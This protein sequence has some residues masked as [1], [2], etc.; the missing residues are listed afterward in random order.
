MM[1]KVLCVLLALLMVFSCVACGSGSGKDVSITF[2]STPILKEAEMQTFIDDFEKEHP[3]IHVELEYQTWEGIAEKLQIALSTGDTPDVYLDGAART[4]TLPA[5]GVLAPVDDVVGA[6]D[7]WQP[8]VKSFGVMDGTHYLV[9]ASQIGASFLTVNV[10]LAK[11]LGVYDMLPED[12]ISWTLQD[13]YEFVKACTE[14]GADKGI[15]GTMLYAGS[16]TS[17]DVLY[18]LMMSNGGQIIDKE[19]NTCTA[20]SPEC[21]EA[22]EILG[23]IVKNGYCIDGAALTDGADTTTPFLN[24]QYVVALNYAAPDALV[25]LGNMKEKGYISEVP[26]MATYGLPTAEGV[27][28]DSACWGANGLAV[29][30]SDEENKLAASKEFVK[31]LVEKKN[32][33][34]TVWAEIPNY[35]PSRNNDAEFRSDSAAIKEEVLFRQELTAKYANFDFG[36][37]ESYWSE[38]RNYFYPELQALYSGEKIAQEAMDSFVANVDK[39]LA[40]Q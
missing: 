19:T 38:V 25:E 28:M 11:E 31:Y 40:N 16:P 1:K 3:N 13:F 7:D 6:F 27:T 20:N 24:G 15:K 8:S 14:A 39:I 12:R 23:N 29:F 22:V 26:E 5:L 32:F 37:L 30:N 35:S 21:V 18:S 17:D 9:P 2:W 33:A 36:I 34:E 4:T 10:T